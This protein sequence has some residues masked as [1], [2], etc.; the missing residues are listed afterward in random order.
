[1]RFFR[2]KQS[3][4]PVPFQ[5]I[6]IHPVLALFEAQVKEVESF[7]GDNGLIVHAKTLKPIDEQV[8][9]NVAR[10]MGITAKDYLEFSLGDSLVVTLRPKEETIFPIPPKLLSD[11]ADTSKIDSIKNLFKSKKAIFTPD[12]ATSV[13]VAECLGV[14]VPCTEL[15]YEFDAGYVGI[16]Q[17][18]SFLKPPDQSHP[19]IVNRM[20]ILAMYGPC[21]GN[22]RVPSCFCGP[23]S[24][25]LKNELTKPPTN[26]S[27]KQLRYLK[28]LEHQ[29]P[30]FLP[31]L[32]QSCQDH[33][34]VFQHIFSGETAEHI[35]THKELNEMVAERNKSELLEVIFKVEKNYN[36]LLLKSWTVDSLL[37]LYT[38][39]DAK[40]L[41]ELLEKDRFGRVNFSDLQNL[42][43]EDR[44][45]RLNYMA[46][47]VLKI[48]VASVIRAVRLTGFW[49]KN[50]QLPANIDREWKQKSNK[51]EELGTSVSG[52]FLRKMSSGE[53]GTILDKVFHKFS[54]KVLAIDRR[55]SDTTKI[56]LSFMTLKNNS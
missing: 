53:L 2:E 6:A 9:G 18:C 16:E 48:P 54:H 1:M 49:I 20:D 24:Q 39:G 13:K 36:P 40:E 12:L 29:V 14:P 32:C 44:V 43:L 35:L 22:H 23:C 27:A 17:I 46:A 3:K 10:A 31:S 56:R 11:K 42:I 26:L 8:L 30:I 55:H 50:R 38:I 15:D 51:K 4:I 34:R 5:V 47:Q 7:L 21:R 45:I 19:V 25:E 37:P 41:I 52:I 33:C 28:L